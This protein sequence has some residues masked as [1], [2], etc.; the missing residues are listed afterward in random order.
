ME[1]KKYKKDKYLLSDQYERFSY[2]NTIDDI[3][4]E[5]KNN[6]LYINYD[7]KF[8]WNRLWP[9]KKFKKEGLNVLVAGCGANQASV[10][11]YNNPGYS[12]TGV[13]ISKESIKNNKKLIKKHNLK[14]LL[15]ICEDFRLLNFDKKFDIIISTGV[16]HH[17][18]NPIS[19]LKYFEKNL[20]E[21]G[22]IILMVYGKIQIY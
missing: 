21:D 2:P 8:F 16:I 15:L 17:L 5:I 11:S 1:Q 6:N 22:V 3:E 19:A 13:D 4:N 20:K 12:F 10:L 9:E 7:P 18:E 14:N